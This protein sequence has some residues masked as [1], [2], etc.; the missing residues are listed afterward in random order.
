MAT[1]EKIRSK[2]VFLLIVI[3][4][5]LLAFI[6]GD[7]IS[8]GRNLFGKGTRI[9]KAGDKNIEINEYQQREQMLSNL[10]KNEGID[11]SLISSV[12]LQQLID[13]AF[14]D[15]AVERMGI[16]IDDK[17][18][19][20]YI[21]EAPLPLVSN[22][23]ERT[24]GPNVDPAVA[25][26]MVNNPPKY[27]ISQESAQGLKQSWLDME[28][29]VRAAAKRHLYEKM[30]AGAIKPNSLERKDMQ[31]RATES[32]KVNLAVKR[33]DDAL[34]SQ[35]TVSD[36]EI[37][38]LY[39]EEKESFKVLDP[40][41][42]IGF[43]YTAV[44]PSAAD[45]AEAQKLSE[46]AAQA[47]AQGKSINAQLQKQ[48]IR[49][50]KFSAP[51]AY[52]EAPYNKNMIASAPV[53]SVISYRSGEYF[54]N[55]K[56]TGDYVANDTVKLALFSVPVADVAI[57]KETLSSGVNVD[58]VAS[59]TGNK[60]QL[61]ANEELSIQNPGVRNSQMSSV[62]PQLDK[63][64]VGEVIT[65][66]EGD[67][68]NPAYIARVEK[69][70]PT[71]VYQFEAANYELTPSSNTIAEA[72]EKLEEFGAKNKNADAFSK[73]Y[74]ASGYEYMPYSINAM[75]PFVQPARNN[76]F[77]LDVLP[78]SSAIVQWAMGDVTSG[79]VSDVYD[80]NDSRN[81]V[82]Y[83]A[84]IADQAEEYRPVNDPLVKERLTEMI[85]RRKA[86]DAL[87]KQYSSMNDINL[88]AQAMGTSVVP[89]NDH[90]FG[91]SR[92][93]TDL[94]VAA[95]IANTAPGT[96]VYVVKG[97]NGVYAYQVVGKNSNPT[98]ANV[99][100]QNRTYRSIHGRYDMPNGAV[101]YANIGRLL[102]GNK[103]VENN[104]YELMGR[105]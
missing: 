88:I 65:V 78:N 84:V 89:E 94:P 55:V 60:A 81:P 32:V 59:R 24:F 71:T 58:S 98:P 85:K 96:K 23:I 51:L 29:Q 54:V 76:R 39:N 36:A 26:D 93:V 68:N 82:L 30:M 44:A 41:T 105:K 95:R 16:E 50:N 87:V 28:D 19:S 61:L 92:Y 1:L 47:L 86:G 3:G 100:S 27:G 8:N 17:D 90:R 18:L 103:K 14:I 33:I 66:S 64:V 46:E 31:A 74:A 22:Y 99:N 20:Y 45:L 67:A 9:A 52:I 13:E 104:R 34:L 83:L 56:K 12:A 10:Y 72:R 49:F 97:D 11:G 42:T 25:N 79:E 21:Y 35:Y 80:N 43:V 57:L 101:P 6:V 102:R 15:Q 77:G 70:V 40:T 53:D 7:A 48:G 2:S 37:N 91:G 38:A 73:N 62:M 75:T 5:A 4:V 69:T 63:A